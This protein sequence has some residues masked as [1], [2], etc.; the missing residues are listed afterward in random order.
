[1]LMIR[2][3]Q[4]NLIIDFYTYFLKM[5]LNRN[6]L[7]AMIARGTYRGVPDVPRRAA[8]MAREG[9]SASERWPEVKTGVVVRAVRGAGWRHIFR[10]MRLAA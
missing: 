4:E 7:V 2:K 1:M 5:S 10:E 8:R 9:V 3:L 6:F